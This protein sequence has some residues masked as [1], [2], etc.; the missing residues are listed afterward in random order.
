MIDYLQLVEGMAMSYYEPP[1]PVQ[2]SV[3]ISYAEA[4]CA[5]QAC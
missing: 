3:F 4:K 5:N 1:D 2:L